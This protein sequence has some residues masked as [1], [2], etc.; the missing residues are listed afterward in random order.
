MAY[1]EKTDVSISKTKGEI[2]GLL[3]KHNASGF[4]SFEEAK[5]AIIV[6]EMNARRIRFD[7]PI[8]DPKE[9]DYFMTADEAKDYGMVDEVI[10]P[11]KAI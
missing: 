8:P 3:R 9:R 4:G 7:L 5:R 1:A 2:D 10:A 11:R 6:F